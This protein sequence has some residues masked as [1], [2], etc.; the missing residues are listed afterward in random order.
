VIPF[1]VMMNSGKMQATSLGQAIL[2]YNIHT[3]LLPLYLILFYD[4]EYT[5]LADDVF[6]S[7]CLLY[8]KIRGV[9]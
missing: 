8:E 5:G 1:K 4:V 2:K 9:R 7:I 6:L 3:F